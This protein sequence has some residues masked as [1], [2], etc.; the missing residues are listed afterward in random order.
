MMVPMSGSGGGDIQR[1]F[2]TREQTRAY[3]DKI[4]GVYDTLAEASE[5]KL[6]DEALSMMGDMAGLV[7]LEIGA[8]T[9]H[10]A[11]ALREAV[12]ERGRV[13]ACDLSPKMLGQ[14]RATCGGDR[15]VD[16]LCCDGFHLPLADGATD[17]LFM[18]F[19]LELFDTPE[20]PGV[21]AEC[22]RVL[23]KGARA[24]FVGMSKE[25]GPEFMVQAYEWVHRHFPNYVD[26][27]PIHLS[28]ALEEAGFHILRKE[29]RHIW[30]PVELV[31][32]ES[33]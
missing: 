22:A 9:G 30:V 6:R 16:L 1:V 8:G 28:R 10:G 25:G 14:T 31:I 2:N 33:G 17:A 7:A 26:C 29:I 5:G 12:G 19:T 27:R 4:S 20:I 24:G 3:Y 11:K 23:R 13:I 32:A 18:S 15:R 21:L